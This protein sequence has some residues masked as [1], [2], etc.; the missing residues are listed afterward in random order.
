MLGRAALAVLTLSFLSQS[1][2]PSPA[3]A[4]ERP[5]EVRVAADRA[6]TT[7]KG[8]VATVERRAAEIGA[9]VLAEGGNAVDAAIATAFALAVTYPAAGNLGG[10][11]F[12]LVALADG[13]TAAID[14]R[15][16]APRRVDERHFLDARGSIDPLKVEFG[17]FVAGVPGSVAGL[18]E[19]HRRF[20]TRPWAELVRPARELAERG[21]PVDA[22]LAR[23]IAE[24]AAD[25]RRFPASARL[26]LRPD[27]TPRVEGDPF[28]PS[29]LANCLR[30][31]EEGGAKAFYEGPIA[32]LIAAEMERAG[33]PM[34]A[35]DLAVYRPV[36]RDVLVARYRGNELLLMPPPSSGGVALAQILG[37]L[38][39]LELRK[40]GGWDASARHLFAEASRRAFAQR[41]EFLGDPDA[42]PVPVAEMLA[43]ERLDSL[44]ATIDLVRATASESL[45]PPLSDPAAAAGRERSSTTHISVVDAAGNAVA[46]T[47]TLEDSYGGRLVAEGTGFLLN[48]ELHDFNPGPGLTDRKGRIG[49]APNLVRPGRRPLSSMTPCIVRR[50]G[51]VTLVTGSPGGRSIISTVSQ[52]V[53]SVLEFGTTA[54][55]AV[56]GARQHQPWFP[57]ALDVE[58]G[59]D[60]AARAGLEQRGH[61]LRIP[62]DGFQGDAH[63]IARVPG[64]GELRAVADRR[65]DGWVAA[66][67]E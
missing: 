21:F 62:K 12:M 11:G 45:G 60:A 1:L 7:S 17:H 35:R 48:N 22:V 2:S 20:A 57:D 33:A 42:T 64:S 65:I 41:A 51:E 5:A 54:D 14:Y 10:G 44:R 34:D 37:I 8:A 31:I 28:V 24:Y 3:V 55:A 46:N 36:V 16:I 4:Q 61:L 66:P 15:E 47:T 67:Q 26:F 52:V 39:P 53:L 50:D 19:A 23:G 29:D 40:H 32:A 27:G 38:E 63:S 49:T 13:R 58:P 43:P 56:A 30:W 18:E 9:R 59:V 25:F 6:L